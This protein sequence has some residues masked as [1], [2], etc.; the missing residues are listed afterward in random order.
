[1]LTALPTFALLALALCP[2]AQAQ[3]SLGVDWV[4]TSRADLVWVEAEQASGT[5]V[6]EFDGLLRPPLQPYL[7]LDHGRWSLQ[8]GLSAARLSTTSWNLAEYTRSAAGAVRPSADV[9]RWIAPPGHHGAG[10]WVGAG[11]YGVVPL[12]SLSSS[13]D[14]AE[15]DAD[16]REYARTVRSRIGGYG[17]RL[18]AGGLTWLTPAVGVGLRASLVGYRGQ[19]LQE[20]AL[21]STTFVYPEVGLRLQLQRP[22]PG[23]APPPAPLPPPPPPPPPGAASPDQKPPPA[24]LPQDPGRVRVATPGTD[25]GI[26]APVP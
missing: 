5:L 26:D 20:D 11:L 8:L 1:M 16:N 12:A 17:L 24:P 13:E 19:Q 15:E 18:S 23:D 7:G 3:V 4:P 14:T 25:G 9:L 6:G 2:D 10:F 21:R 22:G